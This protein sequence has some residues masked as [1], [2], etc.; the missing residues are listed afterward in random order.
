MYYKNIDTDEDTIIIGRG[1]TLY[2][3]LF[4]YDT[5]NT[6]YLLQADEKII[7]GV[8]KDPTQSEYV[9]KK[10]LTNADEVEG[11]YPLVI[12]AEETNITAGEYVYDIG[13]E[14]QDGSFQRKQRINKNHQE[15]LF[16]FLITES[17]SRK[18]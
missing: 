10:E 13:V 18:E 17:V 1:T 12:S 7:F 2:R 11:G 14:L 15:S 4:L 6:P 3:T 16:P 8:K 5:E 9:I